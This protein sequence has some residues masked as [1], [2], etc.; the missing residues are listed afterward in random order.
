MSDVGCRGSEIPVC[1]VNNLVLHVPSGLLSLPLFS[2]MGPRFILCLLTLSEVQLI[3]ETKAL[4]P[5][6]ELILASV[7]LTPFQISL[8]LEDFH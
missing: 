7:T 1:L 6:K 3:L 8:Y 5:V 2:S 4:M